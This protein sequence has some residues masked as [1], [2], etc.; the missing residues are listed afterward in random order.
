MDVHCS[1]HIH[2][3]MD[4]NYVMLM[5]TGMI[6]QELKIIHN[7][8]IFLHKLDCKVMMSDLFVRLKNR[9]K[10]FTKLV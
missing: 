8:N 1:A 7:P 10:R 3:S 6:T 2:I 4:V 5:Y 9:M